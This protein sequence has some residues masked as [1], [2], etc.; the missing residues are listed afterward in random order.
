[1]SSSWAVV[2]DE[3]INDKVRI[4]NDI[5]GKKIDLS[6]DFTNEL[7]EEVKLSDYF[8][9]GRPV[10]MVMAYYQCPLLCSQVMNG[11]SEVIKTLEYNAGKEYVILTVSINPDEKSKLAHAKQK[12]Y[13]EHLGLESL[14]DR[15]SFLTGS[16]ENITK[17]TDQLGFRYF[18]SDRLK[19][20]L[21]PAASY[22]LDFDGKI[23]SF[24]GSNK[25]NKDNFK[26]A[27]IAASN[28]KVGTIWEQ[29]ILKCYRFD[30]NAGEYVVFASKIMTL[31]GVITLIVLGTFLIYLW[32]IEFFK[33]FK[34]KTTIPQTINNKKIEV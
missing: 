31:G 14:K 21:H 7:N 26:K 29:A 28:G 16:Q 9:D 15:W 17:L 33:R 6:L 5:Y 25:F 23:S 18:Y 2:K 11:L 34:N 8:Q 3:E 13:A 22:V 1:M 19:Q 4:D 20:Y 12:V 27:I 32:R 10:I 24:F 30:P